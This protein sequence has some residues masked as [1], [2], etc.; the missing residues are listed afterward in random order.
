[1]SACVAVPLPEL[2]IAGSLQRKALPGPSI[3]IVTVPSTLSSSEANGVASF[4]V[5]EP[6]RKRV[7]ADPTLFA[8]AILVDESILATT[9]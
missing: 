9:P 2:Q 3:P 7:L 8:L 4:I 5:S 6:G 1:M